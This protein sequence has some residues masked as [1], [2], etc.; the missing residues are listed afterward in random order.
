MGAARQAK[1]TRVWAAA[2]LQPPRGGQAPLPVQPGAGREPRSGCLQLLL[3]DP[4]P[5]TPTLQGRATQ[6]LLRCHKRVQDSEGSRCIVTQAEA[7]QHVSWHPSVQSEGRT[8]TAPPHLGLCLLHSTP[9][10]FLTSPPVLETH[11]LQ[12]LLEKAGE[13]SFETLHFW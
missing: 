8:P 12:H 13:A 1:A 11:I 2:W 9:S 7:A 3:L 5:P 4:L 6:A 10:S